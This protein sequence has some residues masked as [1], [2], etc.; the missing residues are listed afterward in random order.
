MSDTPTISL[1]INGRFF[2]S[3]WRPARDEIGFVSAHDFRALQFP[4]KLEGLHATHLGA[5]VAVVSD[6]LAEAGIM[7]V[8]EIVVRINAAG[9]TQNGQTPLDVLRANLPAI[10]AL[11]CRY[12]HWHLALSEWPGEPAVAR[13]EESLTPQFAAAVELAQQHGFTFGL[14][15]NEPEL[16]LF[17]TPAACRAMLDAT[18]GLGFVWDLNHTTPT[19]LLAYLDL[20][21][22]MSM[23]H[24]ADTPLPEV[25][26]HLPLGLGAIDFAAYLRALVEGGFAGPAILEIGGLPKSGGYGRDTDEA[27]VASRRHFTDALVL[28]SRR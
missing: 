14:E 18:P 27:L 25:N 11:P 20:I 19:D 26:H 2:A 12:V 9:R 28:A 21:P 24:V 5:E 1:G 3:N 4:G 15:H 16:R 13:L 22:R 17:A 6:L 10:T 8:M 23:L 7:A